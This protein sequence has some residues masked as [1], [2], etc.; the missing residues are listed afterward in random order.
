[1][2]IDMPQLPSVIPAILRVNF[3]GHFGAACVICWLILKK[4]TNLK[5]D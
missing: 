4:G 1:M 3:I 2:V 5:H